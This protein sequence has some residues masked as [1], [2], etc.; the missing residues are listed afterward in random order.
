MIK[1][2]LPV[3]AIIKILIG[4]L[5]DVIKTL[6]PDEIT[7]QAKENLQAT[8]GILYSAL[9]FYGKGLVLSTENDFDDAVY[10]EAVEIC[11]Q[12]AKKYQLE[13]NPLNA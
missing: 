11:E 9:K 6:E 13:L 5:S 3:G 4:Y 7:P 1:L 10:A 8:V 2:A 12:V